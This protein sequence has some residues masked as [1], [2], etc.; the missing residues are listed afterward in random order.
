MLRLVSM[1]I[2]VALNLIMS[3]VLYLLTYRIKAEGYSASLATAPMLCWGILWMLGAAWQA[4]FATHRQVP[5]LL[6][7]GCVLLMLGTGVFL[8]PW[9]NDFIWWMSGLSLLTVGGLLTGLNYQL[10]CLSISPDIAM[11]SLETASGYTGA[12]SIGYSLG[13]VIFAKWQEAGFVICFILAAAITLLTILLARRTVAVRQR[14]LGWM[15]QTSKRRQEHGQ[16]SARRDI[17]AGYSA[18]LI[19]GVVT[20]TVAIMRTMWP[21]YGQEL[22]VSIMHNGMI[23]FTV[24]MVQGITALCLFRSRV[25]L[26]KWWVM[27]AFGGI[28]ILGLGCF[29][30]CQQIVGLYCGAAAVGI[31]SGGAYCYVVFR[32]LSDVEHSVCIASGSEIVVGLSSLLMPLIAALLLKVGSFPLIFGITAGLI[33]FGVALQLIVWRK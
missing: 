23:L 9:S 27:A 7:I 26:N 1:F 31:F 18:W 24:S 28:G 2:P 21:S 8:L 10:F 16:T 17:P 20:L 30:F 6:G 3:G 22:N 4:K 15:E 33:V 29:M 25:L 32:A 14:N 12:W 5:L 19:C 11:G 13:P